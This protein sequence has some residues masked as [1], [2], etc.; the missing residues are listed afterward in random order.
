MKDVDILLLTVKVYE[1]LVLLHIII[2]TLVNGH[3]GS[4]DTFMAQPIQ[5]MQFN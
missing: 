1:H 4:L 3:Q 2:K 5:G